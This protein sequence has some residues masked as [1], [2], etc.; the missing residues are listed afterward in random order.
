MPARSR[1]TSSPPLLFNVSDF[2]PSIER[3]KKVG[4]RGHARV[5]VDEAARVVDAVVDDDVQV[6]LGVVG[7]H[8]GVGEEGGHCCGSECGIGLLVERVGLESD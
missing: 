5:L 4:E 2:A 7:G 3:R 6:L 8:I 1:S